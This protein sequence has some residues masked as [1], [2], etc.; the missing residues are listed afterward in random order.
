MTAASKVTTMKLSEG[1]AQLI[2]DVRD[3]VMREGTGKLEALGAVCPRCGVRLNGVSITAEHWECHQCGYSQDGL[4]LGTGGTL[5]LGMIAGAAVVALLW[6]L[7][8]QAKKS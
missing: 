5:A 1:E 6:W 2:R 7:N 3:R 8:E 4:K